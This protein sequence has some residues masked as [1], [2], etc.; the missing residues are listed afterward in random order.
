MAEELS[1][2]KS[3]GARALVL[4]HEKHLCQCLEVWRQAKAAKVKLPET[5][6]EDYQTVE[7]LIIHV[8][9]SA[10]IYLVWT[11]K[12]L[13]LPDPNIKPVPE[14]GVIEAE[15]ESYLE[16]ILERWRLPLA[17]ISDEKLD[18]TPATYAFG[19]L[20]KV[21]AMLEHAVMHPIRH[22]FQLR[23]LMQKQA[24]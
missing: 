3:R 14:A 6:D 24:K 16:H 9:R 12:N 5:D 23:E 8:F 21:D 19:R 10:V 17:D 22:E 15:A 1:N 13:G 4:L 7:T 18:A 2:Y 11:C 20:F